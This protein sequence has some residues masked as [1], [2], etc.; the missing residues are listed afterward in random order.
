MRSNTHR[1]QLARFRLSE[2]APPWD[3]SAL[4]DARW[5]STRTGTAY[6]GSTPKTRGGA[7]A[8]RSLAGWLSGW[9][10]VWINALTPQAKGRVERANQTLQDRLIKGDAITEHQLDG[11]GTGISSG[12]YAEVEP[13]VRGGTARREPGAP[14][15]GADGG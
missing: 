2:T 12:I 11:S 8:R 3:V 9:R 15:V 7:T 4:A 1:R 10:S 14:A 13:E 6:S 5:R